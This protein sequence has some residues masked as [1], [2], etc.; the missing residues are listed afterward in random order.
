MID[1]ALVATMQQSLDAH[2]NLFAQLDEITLDRAYHYLSA[3]EAAL[4]PSQTARWTRVPVITR[5]LREEGLLDAP[6]IVWDENY[7]STGNAALLL[8]RRL[9]RKRVWI[10]SHLDQISYLTDPGKGDRY[11]LVPFCDHVQQNGRRPALALAYDLAQDALTVRARGAIEVQGKSVTFVVE[12]GGPLVPGTRVVYESDLVWDRETNRLSGHLDDTVAVTASLLAANVL[13]HYPV[14][15][16]IGLTDE[17]EGPPGDANQSFGRG[18]RRLVN[19]MP[20]PELAIIADVHEAGPMIDGP[21]PRDLYPGD[22]AVFAER[23]SNG[24]GS[25]TP[26]NLYAFQQ[27]LA[28]A[29][30]VRGIRLR[31]NW[32]GYVSSSEDIN[33]VTLTPH[34]ALIGVL[35][36]NRHH[37][38]DRPSANLVDVVDLAKVFVAFTLL[39][40]SDVWQVMGG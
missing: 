40:H 28:A 16:F 38:A 39:V 19:I 8:G 3:I 7:G 34:V 13:R 24:R 6:R 15:V 9:K 17:G 20:R 10:L 27:H 14:E 12:E 30:D 11:P 29:L 36:A 31:E 2:P 33:A 35:C 23:S 26:P 37:A 22:G 1:D 5:L 21:A 18:G 32:G 25:V 4:C